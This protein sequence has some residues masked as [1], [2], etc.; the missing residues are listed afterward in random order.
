ML[1]ESRD[2]RDRIQFE[3]IPGGRQFL[4]VVIN[5]M[6]ENRELRMDYKSFWSDEKQDTWIQPYFLA[7]GVIEPQSL[8]DMVADEVMQM[9][10]MYK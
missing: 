3:E 2:L 4:S 5:A 8:R 9:Y 7:V 10:K 6:R 1:N